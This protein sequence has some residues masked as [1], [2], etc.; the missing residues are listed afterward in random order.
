M[1]E[2]RKG[3]TIFMVRGAPKET[4]KT[5]LV[6]LTSVKRTTKIGAMGLAPALFIPRPGAL[7]DKL[8]THVSLFS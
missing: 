4:K 7:P 8:Y 1:R 5:G 6:G 3:K 2:E